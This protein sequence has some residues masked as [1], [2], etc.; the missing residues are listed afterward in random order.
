M[1]PIVK[2]AHKVMQGNSTTDGK[3]IAANADIKY[4]DPKLKTS[5]TNAKMTAFESGI[6][7]VVGGGNYEE[8]VC[9]KEYAEVKCGLRV[10]GEF[11]SMYSR[12]TIGSSHEC[13][14]Y[15]L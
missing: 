8:C 1:L 10:Y 11:H 6:V 2:Y 9:V 5:G 15:I 14:F 3:S 12:G 4:I 13:F 7:L